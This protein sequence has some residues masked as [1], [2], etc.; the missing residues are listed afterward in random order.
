M[1][2]VGA[3]LERGLELRPVGKEPLEIPAKEAV[4]AAG[5][6]AVKGWQAGSTELDNL[7]QAL[8]P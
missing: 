1:P 5:Q 3:S 8:A 6:E 7:L 2:Q 4:L